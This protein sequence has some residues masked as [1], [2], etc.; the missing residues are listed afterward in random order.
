MSTEKPTKERE[1]EKIKTAM[2]A[3]GLVKKKEQT[4]TANPPETVQIMNVSTEQMDNVLHTVS[5]QDENSSLDGSPSS[6][7]TI[8]DIDSDDEQS[9][10]ELQNVL[11]PLLIRQVKF[12]GSMMAN[13]YVP[14]KIGEERLQA[15]VDSG[16]QAT[17]ITY[18]V[19]EKLNEQMHLPVFRSTIQL[20][21]HNQRDIKQSD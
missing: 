8:S 16:A 13:I 17:L 14:I 9:E 20:L 6:P 5:E 15:L 7:K 4:Q 11:S 1:V 21:D 10:E 19:F 12:I 2:S 3:L 18:D